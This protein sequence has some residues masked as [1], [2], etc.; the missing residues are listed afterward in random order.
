MPDT[1]A[2]TGSAELLAGAAGNWTLDPARTT[3]EFNTKAMWGLAKVKGTMT[4]LEGSGTVGEDGSVT[5]TFVVDTASIATKNKKR[6]E[7]LRSADFFEVVKYPTLTYSV[8][9]VT[10]TDDGKLKVSG[11]LAVHGRTRPVESV[12]TVVKGDPGRVTLSVEAAVDR[13]EW[14]MTWA[15]MGAKVDNTVV[16]KADFVRA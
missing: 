11:S 9:G 8:T 3:V 12:A 7:H 5:G 13:S 15:K 14:G 16:V 1:N 4:A 10:P 6:D 2:G